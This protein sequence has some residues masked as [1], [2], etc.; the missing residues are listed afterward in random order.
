MTMLIVIVVME[1][2]VGV[3]E[4]SATANSY[5]PSK[6]DNDLATGPHVHY[7][8]LIGSPG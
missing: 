7:L 6:S 8:E 4:S 3:V 5:A 2:L 1:L